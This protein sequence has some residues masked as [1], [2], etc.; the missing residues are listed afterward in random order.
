MEYLLEAIDALTWQQ[1]VM[2]VIGGLGFCGSLLAFVLSFIPPSQISVGSNVVWFS[3]LIIGSLVV[4]IAPFI[5]YASRKPHWENSDSQFEPFHWEEETPQTLQTA[6]TPNTPKAP[7]S[8]T[9][10]DRSPVNDK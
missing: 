4:V 10:T 2:W 9:K 5:I 1:V 8:T 6:S 7:T 3:V